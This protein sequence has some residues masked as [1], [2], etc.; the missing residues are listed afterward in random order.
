MPIKIEVEGNFPN[1]FYRQ[2]VIEKEGVR[3]EFGEIDSRS[4]EA[5]ELALELI[6]SAYDLLEHHELFKGNK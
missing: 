1:R 5:K 3:I 6:D 4:D 2:L